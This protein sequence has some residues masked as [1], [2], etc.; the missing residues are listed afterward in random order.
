M[1]T[2]SLLQPSQPEQSS[3]EWWGVQHYWFSYSTAKPG[4]SLPSPPHPCSL[5]VDSCS[6]SWAVPLLLGPTAFANPALHQPNKQSGSM[7]GYQA[8]LL[9]QLSPMC[10]NQ[11]NR[12]VWGWRVVA[13]CNTSSG[14][15]GIWDHPCRFTGNSVSSVAPLW[16][17]WKGCPSPDLD[18]LKIS[19][20]HIQLQ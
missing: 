12:Q 6:F 9:K 13:K 20:W 3:A 19:I 11:Q 7:P 16:L 10:Q 1:V 15:E 14:K 5:A 4:A 8:E 18:K 17:L 2:I